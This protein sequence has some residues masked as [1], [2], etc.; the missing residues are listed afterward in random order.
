MTREAGGATNL[1]R[2]QYAYTANDSYSRKLVRTEQ[3]YDGGW[4]DSWRAVFKYDGLVD[5]GYQKHYRVHHGGNEFVRG[6]R[7]INGIESFWAYAKHR[8][9][10]FH[11]ITPEMFYLHLKESEF[12][13]NHRND[14]LYAILLELL[15]NNPLY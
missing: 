15:R 9:A 1:Q 2:T 10:K 8:L 3:G 5:I 14:N 13:F 4:V 7:H 6:K 11:G 12:R